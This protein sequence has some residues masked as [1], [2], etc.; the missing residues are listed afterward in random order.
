MER[1]WYVICTK[2]RREKKVAAL[3]A[4]K[5]I[6]HYC[7]LTKRE[8]KTGSQKRI[9]I[10]PLFS[11]YVFVCVQENE[12]PFLK[13]IPYVSNVVYWKSKPAVISS[14]EV[15]AIRLMEESYQD[16]QLHKTAVMPEKKMYVQKESITDFGGNVLTIQ[17]KG[18]IV[19]LPSL[20]FK[21]TARVQREGSLLAERQAA[22]NSRFPRILNPL[23]LF[24]F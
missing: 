4:K 19:T 15:D 3:L 7:P 12:I 22:Y 8:R 2:F 5:G 13:R 20:G 21:M 11:T 10:G 24:G 6:E 23:Y 14:E 1:K 16:I 18:L 17:H 9:E